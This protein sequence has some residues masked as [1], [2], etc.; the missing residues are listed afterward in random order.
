LLISDDI[1]LYQPISSDI[2]YILLLAVCIFACLISPAMAADDG[3]KK[4]GKCEGVKGKVLG[5][6]G[7]IKGKLNE[8]MAKVSNS[9]LS[10]EDKIRIIGIIE[11]A[12]AEIKEAEEKIKSADNCLDLREAVLEFRLG[13]ID[14]SRELRILA[15]EHAVER[16]EKQLQKLHNISTKLSE[17][18]IDTSE[19]NELID[20]AEN[21]VDDVGE[22]ISAGTV[23]PEDIVNAELKI[24]K[25][26]QEARSM[27]EDYRSQMS[28]QGGKGTFSVPPVQNP[29]AGF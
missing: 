5:H 2:G 23:T 9:R 6:I 19:L 3:V 1:R 12:E 18:G 7:H 29:A 10:E 16:M 4:W 14:I 24:V 8:L 15:Y 26:F 17:K 13:W 22:K 11:S 21:A 27:I 20:E 25:A 28:E